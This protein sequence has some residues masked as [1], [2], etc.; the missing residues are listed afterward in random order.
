M[1]K[2]T[3]VL[4][5]FRRCNQEESSCS[6]FSAGGDTRGIRWTLPPNADHAQRPERRRVMLSHYPLAVRPPD[7]ECGIG[8]ERSIV[9]YHDPETTQIYIVNR[10]GIWGTGK[11]LSLKYM[12]KP[13]MEALTTLVNRV[14]SW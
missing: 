4:S 1:R 13:L 3:H 11:A 5:L 12:I 7:S 6:S 14:I 8:R 10:C 2:R 9:F